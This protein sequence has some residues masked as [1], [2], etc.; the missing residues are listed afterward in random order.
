MPKP[1][2]HILGAGNMGSIL[3]NALSNIASL[4]LIHRSVSRVESYISSGSVLTVHSPH[5]NRISTIPAP[6]IPI[7]NIPSGTQITNLIVGTK[8]PQTVPAL[9]I[10]RDSNA[11]NKKTNVLFLQNG[12]GMYE[13]LC[14]QVWKDAVER[15][16]L[17]FSTSTHGVKS[18]DTDWTYIHAGVG[19][20]KLA[21]YPRNDGSSDVRT[22]ENPLVKLLETVDLG[23]VPVEY[24]E[25]VILQ[26]EKLIMNS[27]MN[28]ISAV[29]QC[30]NGELLELEAI[31]DFL[32]GIISEA[33]LVYKTHLEKSGIVPTISQKE[34]DDRYFN[35]KAQIDFNR[36]IIKR[37]SEAK[38]S[39]AQDVA[40]LRDTEVDNINGY[41]VGLADKYGIPAPVNKLFV[42]LVKSRL[43]LNRYR[44]SKK[45]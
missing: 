23:L 19:D 43:S 18:T 39:M 6:A 45:N 5:L 13:Q 28:A 9:T 30:Q 44:H 22:I 16:N 21:L 20:L 36:F 17:I 37:N 1:T 8:V 11:L 2:V 25:F 12:M 3:A 32:N 29:F 27:C 24:G 35:V 15:P 34:L 7:T 40:N 31:D 42:G 4:T 10:L 41:I 38:T 14:K 33:I 26:F